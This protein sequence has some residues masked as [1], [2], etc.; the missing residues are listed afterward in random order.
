M[1]FLLV[2]GRQENNVTDSSEEEVK[3]LE[4]VVIFTYNLE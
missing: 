4:K 3:N 1:A 2:D